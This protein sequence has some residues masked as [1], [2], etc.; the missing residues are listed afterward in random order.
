MQ[1]SRTLA[2]G[3]LPGRSLEALAIPLISQHTQYCPHSFLPVDLGLQ[4]V[5]LMFGLKSVCL[6]LFSFVLSNLLWLTLLLGESWA[7]KVMM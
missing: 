6:A 2:D 7:R 3:D 1:K 5:V 4:E